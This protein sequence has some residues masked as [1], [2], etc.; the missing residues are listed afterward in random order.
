[1]GVLTHVSNIVHLRSHFFVVVSETQLNYIHKICNLVDS[2]F[3]QY[4]I[5]HL[6]SIILK[7]NSFQWTW[8]KYTIFQKK[9]AESRNKF[10]RGGYRSTM[11]SQRS[12]SSSTSTTI[13][14]I[15]KDNKLQDILE[16]RKKQYDWI[17]WLKHFSF[18]S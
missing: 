13:A 18:I 6:L 8:K 15:Q 7:F 12:R 1:M 10:K 2:Y 3:K 17:S 11:P 14:L 9:V 16:R 4:I 5:P